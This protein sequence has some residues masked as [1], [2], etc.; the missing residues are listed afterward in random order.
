MVGPRHSVAIKSR[1]HQPYFGIFG[2]YAPFAAGCTRVA[3]LAAMRSLVGC[4]M[5][6][7]LEVPSLLAGTPSPGFPFRFEEG[8]LWVEVTRPEGGRPLAF[9]LDSG[10]SVSVLDLATA[11]ELGVSLGRKVTVEGV[12]GRVPGYWPQRLA[13]KADAV[14][15]PDSYLVLELAGLGRACGRK[16]DG[17]IG[18]DFFRDRTVQIDFLAQRIRILETASVGEGD[19]VLPLRV[20]P[21]GLLVPAGVNGGAPKWLRFDTGCASALHWVTD[22]VDLSR[23]S[24]RKAVALATTTVTVVPADVA[25]GDLTFPAVP[26]DVHA[27]PL[28][29]GEAGLLGNGL[30]ARFQ[31]V[32]VDARQRRVY[33]R[34]GTA[35]VAALVD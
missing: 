22:R 35:T 11:R 10:A 34:K 12:G 15:L 19:E 6:M 14:V 16:L 8:F 17:L 33:L 5:L 1:L 32:T 28:F 20:H 31:S 27:R 25:L 23:H 21:Q 29:S 30:L 2:E 4:L 9:L 3:A 7:L 26:A 13:L 18:A 24:Q